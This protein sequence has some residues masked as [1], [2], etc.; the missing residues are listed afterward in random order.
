MNSLNSLWLS[1]TTKY[2]V[3]V[4]TSIRKINFSKLFRSLCWKCKNSHSYVEKH[5]RFKLINL[6]RKVHS[7]HV[8]CLSKK[9]KAR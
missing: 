2:Y 8:E 5:Y 7:L 6:D 9:L 1:K 3:E 4:V